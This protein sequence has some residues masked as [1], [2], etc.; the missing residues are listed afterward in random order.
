MN[1]THF[2]A[3]KDDEG[4][5]MDKL[6]RRFLT[7]ESLSS[8]YK[9]LRKG[10]I[11]LNGKKCEGNS[12]VSEGDDIQIADFLLSLD[13]AGS[14]KN[15]EAEPVC[16]DWVLFRSEDLLILNKPYDIPVQP[17]SEEKALS[18]YV[19]ADYEYFHQEKDSLSFKCGPLHRLDRKTTGI[20][21]FSQ[22]LKGAQWFS[23]S[24][25]DH[26]SKKTYL[27]LCQGNF[28]GSE[29]WIDNI[30]KNDD[31]KESFHKVSVGEKS[32]KEA[33]THATALAHG[34][35]NGT[36]VTLVQYVIETGRTHQIRSQTSFHGHPLLGDVAYGGKKIDSKITGQDF[37][38][39]AWQLDFP[40]ERMEGLPKKIV[41]GIST[42]F[43]KMLND[44]LINGDSCIK[45]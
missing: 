44:S 40:S 16:E 28:S 15:V 32:G 20:I 29:D 4:R 38:L 25:H 37:F 22:S 1:F 7:Q 11:K 21:V 3:G 35:Y 26:E 9:S 12:R 43:K 36:E 39:H 10:L 30:E 27:G 18:E 13:E 23:K 17:G 42:K 24:I 31:G 5:R 33:V 8:L 14:K 6:L 41:C 2:T 34:K 19:E 45:L